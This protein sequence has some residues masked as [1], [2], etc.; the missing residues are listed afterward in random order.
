M[1]KHGNTTVDTIFVHCAATRADWYAGRSL[2]DKVAEITRWHKANGWATIGYHWLIDRDGQTA[3]GRPE[4]VVGAHVANHNT[5]SIGICLI[6][7]HGSNENDPFEKNYTPAQEESLRDLI[8]EIKDRTPITKIRGHNEVA[9]KACPGFNVSR[10]LAHKP[11]QKALA[12]ST[13]MQASAVQLLAGGGTAITAVA[14][15]DGRAQIVA[16][17]LLGIGLLATAWIMRERIRKWARET[18]E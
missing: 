2:A 15:F 6:G 14:S 7:G 9:A 8:D 16:L 13:T 1:I 10:W 12:E 11:A 17:I 4:N 3:R 18:H 5:G